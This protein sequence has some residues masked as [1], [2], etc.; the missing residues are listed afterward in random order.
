MSGSCLGQQTPYVPVITTT[1]APIGTGATPKK[2]KE[3]KSGYVYGG[4]TGPYIDNIATY[5][6]CMNQCET[7]S[8]CYGWS[9]QNSTNHCLLQTSVDMLF[10][11]ASMMGGSCIGPAAKETH[12]TEVISNSSYIGTRDRTLRQVA[13]YQDCISRCDASTICMG[14]AYRAS[15]RTCQLLTT[16]SYTIPDEQYT[17]GSCIIPQTPY[18]PLSLE[19]YRQQALDQHNFYRAK[20][21]TPPL[22][23]DPALNDIA[24]SYAEHLAVT[25]VMQHSHSNFSGRP[26]G[27]NLIMLDGRKFSY[28]TGDHAV[29]GWYNEIR[30][31]NWANPDASTGVVGHFR[32]V[33][34]KDST[35]LGIGRART[36][37]SLGTIVVGNYFPYGPYYVGRLEDNVLPLC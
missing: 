33:I 27:E 19:K 20:H 24:Q 21:C 18:P 3:I 17:T 22:R 4:A 2:C 28:D 14:W 16:I 37:D 32:Q 12:C 35:R 36:N 26:M 1:N 15:D 6:D 29:D 11:D 10:T 9:Y 30:N 31:Y 13:T 5:R 23:L 34:W 25:K 7:D 8:K